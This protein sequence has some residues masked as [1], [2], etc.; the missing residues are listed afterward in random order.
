MQ[1]DRPPTRHDRPQAGRHPTP[2]HPNFRGVPFGLDCQCCGSSSEDPKLIIR[3][4]NFEL[5]QHNMCTIFY[6]QG[7]PKNWHNFL[8]ALTLPNINDFQNSF[9]ARIRRKFVIIL[10]LKIPHA[11]TVSLHYL[12]S[13]KSTTS[14]RSS[15]KA[16]TC[17]L[18]HFTYLYI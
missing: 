14:Q 5:V 8:Y 15:F 4:I 16:K 17:F 6:I 7:D 10:S 13:Y 12:V 1:A 11:S 3:V 18:K 9:T 2:F